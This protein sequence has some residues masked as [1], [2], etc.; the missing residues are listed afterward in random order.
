MGLQIKGVHLLPQDAEWGCHRAKVWQP[1]HFGNQVLGKT[2][3][4]RYDYGVSCELSAATVDELWTIAILCVLFVTD[5]DG[6]GS[7]EP[8]GLVC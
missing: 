8:H 3:F 7:L 6:R 1:H 4:Q 5:L 2:P